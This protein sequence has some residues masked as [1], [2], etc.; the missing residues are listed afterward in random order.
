MKK[1]RHLICIAGASGSGKTTFVK[2]LISTLKKEKINKTYGLLSLDHYYHDLKDKSLIERSLHNFDAP[3]A[4]QWELIEKHVGKLLKG[5][6]ITCPYYDFATHT[7]IPANEFKIQPPDILIIEG[8]HG[9]YSKMFRDVAT[10]KI[11]V[12]T[13]SDICLCRRLM[14][15]ITERERTAE[16]VIDQYQRT[17]KPMYE[18]HIEPMINL[19]NIIIPEG[20]FNNVAL[21][22]IKEA[23]LRIDNLNDTEE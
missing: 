3:E 12:K 23:I 18:K 19:A 21:K 11:F 4:L 8:I 14:R 5:E 17:V 6:T 20:G 22:V 7:T 9:M 16:F 10:L 2:N 1:E 13:D 15:D